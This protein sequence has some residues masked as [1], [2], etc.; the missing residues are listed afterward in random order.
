[1]RLFVLMLALSFAAAVPPARAADAPVAPA[2]EYDTLHGREGFWRLAR[3]AKGGN[4]WF[5]SPDGNREFL[6]SVTTV[7]PAADARG[8]D[9]AAHL[10]VDYSPSAESAARDHDWAVATLRRVKDAGFKGIGAWSD[11]AL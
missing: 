8:P 10:S 5:V 7:R 1:M 11:P 6:N 3:E 2:A 4:W 9:G